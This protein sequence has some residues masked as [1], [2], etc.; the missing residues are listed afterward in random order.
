[1]LRELPS[2]RAVYMSVIYHKRPHSTRVEERRGAAAGY[3]E[4]VGPSCNWQ[5]NRILRRVIVKNTMFR[6]NDLRHQLHSA[7]AVHDFAHHCDW[8]ETCVLRLYIACVNPQILICSYRWVARRERYIPPP[9]IFVTLITPGPSHPNTRWEKAVVPGD[10]CSMRVTL[11][12]CASLAGR[13]CCGIAAHI[14]SVIFEDLAAVA[15]W[16][17]IPGLGQ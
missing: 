7:G 9:F 8:R 2:L 3:V 5:I 14:A 13:D 10:S 1:M 6:C 16:R 11:P 4:F 17:E 12:S 15:K